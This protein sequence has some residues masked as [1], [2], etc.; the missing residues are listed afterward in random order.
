MRVKRIG[1]VGYTVYDFLY[2]VDSL[3]K[4]APP[5]ARHSRRSIPFSKV[6][7]LFGESWDM[8]RVQEYLYHD[9]LC[10]SSAN[11]GGRALNIGYQLALLGVSVELI[12]EVG[13]DFYVKVPGC[14]LSYAEHLEKVGIPTRP[15]V[16]D[17]RK[18]NTRRT[19]LKQAI[20][21]HKF[22]LADSGLILVLGRRTPSVVAVSDFKGD[23][24][25]FFDDRN[26]SSEVAKFRVVPLEL[27]RKLDGVVVTS[28]DNKFNEVLAQHAYENGLE[29]FFD[30]G[31]FE[32]SRT[33]FQGMIPKSTIIFGNYREIAEVCRSFGFPSTHPELLLRT[34][35][36]GRPKHV[37]LVDKVQGTILIYSGDRDMP[38]QIGPVQFERTGT[39]IGVCDAINGAIIALYLQGYHID[40]CCKAGLLAGSDIWKSNNAQEAMI[41]FEELRRR[42]ESKFGGQPY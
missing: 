25:F 3:E 22:E 27:L 26:V 21:E 17:L 14:S 7:S 36:T 13:D 15:Y 42:Y 18:L 41:D 12:T 2:S 9:A 16:L 8:D 30:V 4:S 28:G 10:V 5:F 32:P 38:V 34:T 11:F 24:I 35:K 33:Y 37:I 29:V 31:L 20:Q 19:D 1:A 39:S 23:D 6:P 40:V